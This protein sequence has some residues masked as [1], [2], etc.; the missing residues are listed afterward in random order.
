MQILLV[1]D[2][3]PGVPEKIQRELHCENYLNEGTIDSF[4]AFAPHQARALHNNVYVVPVLIPASQTNILDS[5]QY[6]R[7]ENLTIQGLYNSIA[8]VICTDIL[9]PDQ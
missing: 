9:L 1:F 8:A 4:L 2:F 5:I 6:N 3:L 7:T